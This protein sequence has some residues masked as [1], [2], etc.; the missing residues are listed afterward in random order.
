MEKEKY[1]I[2]WNLAGYAWKATKEAWGD[3]LKRACKCIKTEAP[4]AWLIGLSEVI[5][6]KDNKYLDILRGEFQGYVMVLPKAYRKDFRSAISVLLI[7]EEGYKKHNTRILDGLGDSLLYEYVDIDTDYGYYRVMNTHLPHT[8]NENKQERY[9]QSRKDLRKK[10]EEA[11]LSECEAYRID[12]D[13]QFILLADANASPRST[14][15]YEL[16]GE[17]N[18]PMLFNATKRTDRDLPTWI[19]PN[20][21][22]NHIDYI[23]YGMGSMFGEVVNIYFNEIISS[24]I[25]NKISDHAIIKGKIRT[26]ITNWSA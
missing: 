18:N 16:A 3:R 14:F 5:P 25:D 13:V 20:Y 26:N 6:G 12:P 1:I 11:I 19:N 7:N 4:D 2:S 8:C 9:Q 17:F 23:F 22:E 24:P 21:G 10:F 15:I